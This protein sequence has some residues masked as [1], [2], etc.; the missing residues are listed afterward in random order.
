VRYEFQ[1]IDDPWRQNK[2][3]KE[4]GLFP[5]LLFGSVARDFLLGGDIMKKPV[6]KR[7]KYRLSWTDRLRLYTE[8]KNKISCLGFNLTDDLLQKLKDK[9][10]V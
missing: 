7:L 3:N 6:L 4:M 9:W 1:T 8:E 10:R 2:P 5:V